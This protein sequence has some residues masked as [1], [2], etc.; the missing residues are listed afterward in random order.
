MAPH[1]LRH[2]TGEDRLPLGVREL[3][4]VEVGIVPF[5]DEVVRPMHYG[6]GIRRLRRSG[7]IPLE[8]SDCPTDVG[9]G[10]DPLLVWPGVERAT[11]VIPLVNSKP[12]G[13]GAR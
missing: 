1:R 2:V 8:D 6:L 13:R 9:F 3:L 5:E 11:T 7:G 4:V 12:N 10:F